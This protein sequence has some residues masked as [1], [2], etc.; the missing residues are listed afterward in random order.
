MGDAASKA[1]QSPICH[2]L[3]TEETAAAGRPCREIR[4]GSALRLRARAR[5]RSLSPLPAH[6]GMQTQGLGPEVGSREGGARVCRGSCLPLPEAL[7]GTLV[8]ND[9]AGRC[10]L[11]RHQHHVLIPAHLVEGCGDRARGGGS[12][13]LAHVTPAPGLN[14]QYLD[15]SSHCRASPPLLCPHTGSPVCP[16]PGTCGS[17][18][19]SRCHRSWST[20]SMRSMAPTCRQWL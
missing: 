2:A 20:G 8:V 11:P 3:C 5:A 17:G 9:L 10:L 18:A 16:K 15:T 14:K 1:G 13:G 12:A 7:G 6:L 4:Q 19:A